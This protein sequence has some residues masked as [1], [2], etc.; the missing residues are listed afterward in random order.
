MHSSK[1]NLVNLLTVT[2]LLF[3]LSVC[4]Q[5]E[6][7]H[8]DDPEPL[9]NQ[10]CEALNAS[11]DVCIK[12]VTCMWCNDPPNCM[13]YPVKNIL[14]S[15]KDCALN[16]ARWGVC[17][18]NFEA[19]IIS[20]SVIGG[21]LI[22]GITLCFCKC[23]GCCCFSGNSKKYAEEQRRMESDREERSTRQDERKKDRQ[24]RNDDIRRKYGLVGGE[25]SKYE[26]FDNEAVA[27]SPRLAHTHNCPPR[28]IQQGLVRNGDYERLDSWTPHTHT[29]VVCI[30]LQLLRVSVTTRPIIICQLFSTLYFVSEQ[31]GFCSSDHTKHFISF[32]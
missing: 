27:W 12:N 5:S 18:L 21:V 28:D 23:C 32:V 17:W 13:V 30:L 15:T 10:T 8:A 20:M 6:S 11:C 9:L 14:P 26:K 19:L 24:R 7:V 4:F 22:I 25:G 31:S 29:M 16:K 2:W 1:I 3:A